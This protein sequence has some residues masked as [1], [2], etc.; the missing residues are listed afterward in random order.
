MVGVEEAMVSVVG[1][2]HTGLGLG[3]SSREGSATDL[4]E[5]EK[6]LRK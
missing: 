2:E 4:S 6:I 5:V 3:F 1:V